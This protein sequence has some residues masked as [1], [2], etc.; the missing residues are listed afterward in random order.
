MNLRDQILGADDIRLVP[1]EVPEWKATVYVRML[2]GTERDRFEASLVKGQGK[3]RAPDLANL[4]ARLV[5]LCAVDAEGNRIFKDEDVAALGAKAAAPLDRLFTA[6]QSLN[7]LT[8]KDVEELAGNSG[9]A[10]SAVSTS[11][12]PSP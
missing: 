4:R 7:G 5:V 12:S 1:V 2:S 3:Q 9:G 11:G 6:A 10:P 8:E